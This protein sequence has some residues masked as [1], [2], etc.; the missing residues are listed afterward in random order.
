[1]L[2]PTR[3]RGRATDFAWSA[4][5]GTAGEDERAEHRQDGCSQTE[6]AIADNPPPWIVG[7]SEHVSSSHTVPVT[8]SYGMARRPL[9]NKSHGT[10]F[11]SAREAASGRYFAV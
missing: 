3:G 10:G 4:G 1:M 9:R 5:V 8:Q 11:G 6:D 2:F 7:S